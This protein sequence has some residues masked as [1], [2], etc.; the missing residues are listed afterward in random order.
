MPKCRECEEDVDELQTVQV[1]R[2]KVK[3]CEDCA[4]RVREQLEIGEASEEVVRDM[5]GYKGR[6]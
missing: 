5:M 3:L 6:W 1:G 4:D 2:K